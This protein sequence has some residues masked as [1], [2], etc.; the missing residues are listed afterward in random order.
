MFTKIY[1]ATTVFSGSDG[2]FPPDPSLIKSARAYLAS[3]LARIINLQ[4]FVHLARRKWQKDWC[5]FL[6]DILQ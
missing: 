6:I 1:K 2:R 3:L 5:T 4:Y